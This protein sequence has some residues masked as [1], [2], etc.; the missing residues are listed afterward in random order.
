MR[1][2][3]LSG[4][5]FHQDRHLVNFRMSIL[6]VSH[7]VGTSARLLGLK[8]TEGWRYLHTT[9]Y[10]RGSE[11]VQDVP[12][13]PKIVIVWWFTP[14]RHRGLIS[15]HCAGRRGFTS[16]VP[17]NA[18]RTILCN[19]AGFAVVIKHMCSLLFITC[20][21]G[22]WRKTHGDV[23]VMCRQDTPLLVCDVP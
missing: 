1:K 22:N 7:S 12:Y 10:C 2:H 19:K 3:E 6:A 8:E 4:L 15:V 13:S 5:D 23:I 17:W 9:V 20:E 18:L 21:L 11:H 16:V 14:Y